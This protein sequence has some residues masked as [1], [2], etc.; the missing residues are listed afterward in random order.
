MSIITTFEA[1]PN[2]LFTL[3]ATL[4]DTNNGVPPERL[5]SWAT[6]STLSGAGETKLLSNTLLEAKRLKLVAEVDGRLRVGETVV[7]TKGRGGNREEEFRNYMNGLLF[8]KER[9]EQSGQG[10]FAVAL[11][12]LLSCDPRRPLV[13]K[14]A[15]QNLLRNDLGDL[16]E[17][18]ELGNDSSYQNLLYWA[19]YL[20]FAVIV[21]VGDTRWVIPDPSAA[22]ANAMP[23]VFN[24]RKTLDID[25]FMKKLSGILPVLEDGA[26]R[27]LV[28]GS[29][30]TPSADTDNLSI[31]TSLALRRLAD[32]GD[33]VL[34]SVADARARIMNFGGDTRRVSKVSWS[35][36]NH[37]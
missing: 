16:F 28:E 35:G 26:V 37:A 15:P 17:Q 7:R 23:R 19:R 21:G 11:A 1:V 20:G 24:D 22:I 9:A 36:V 33:L 32:R 31:S 30:D 14:Q 4:A 12:W 27:N 2:R 13:F 10:G 3:Y 25:P 18:S 29:R 5:A 8:S 6:P 34:D